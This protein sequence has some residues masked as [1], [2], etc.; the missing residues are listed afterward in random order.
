MPE[1]KT[2]IVEKTV[3]R[4]SKEDTIELFQLGRMTFKKEYKALKPIYPDIDRISKLVHFKVIWKRP[5]L[6]DVIKP[7]ETY[8]TNDQSQKT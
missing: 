2:T 7:L 5:V 6:E 8:E 1:N 4:V 3:E